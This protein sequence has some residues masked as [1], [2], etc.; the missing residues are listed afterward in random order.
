[1]ILSPLSL[2]PYAIP[3]ALDLYGEATTDGIIIIALAYKF[4]LIFCM[5]KIDPSDLFLN[6]NM[7]GGTIFPYVATFT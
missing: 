2:Y 6:G 1:M 3:I 5:Y 7:C 4:E